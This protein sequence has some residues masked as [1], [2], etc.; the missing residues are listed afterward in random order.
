MS[1]GPEAEEFVR[2]DDD[3]MAELKKRLSAQEIVK[4]QYRFVIGR[5]ASVLR[6]PL[7]GLK[8]DI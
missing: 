8:D 4:S 1:L 7:P 5:P 2:G 3:V 6:D